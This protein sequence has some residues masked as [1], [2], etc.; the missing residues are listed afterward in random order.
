MKLSIAMMVKNESKYL[1]KCLEA[2]KP[3]MKKV[4]S[5]LIIVDTGS[6]DNTV[7]IAREY[8]D[9]VYFHPW[10]NNFSEMRNITIGYSRG[11]WLFIVDGDEILQEHE[12]LVNFLNGKESNKFNTAVIQIKNITNETNEEEGFSIITAPRLFRNDE[13]FHYEGAVHNQAIYKAPVRKLQALLVHYGYLH[14]DKELMERKFQRTSSI[15]KSELE[16]NPDNVYYLFQLSTTYSMHQEYQTALECILKAVDVV[17]KHNL[18]LKQ[19]YYVFNEC[20]IVYNNLGMYKEAEEACLKCF[21]IKKGHLDVH[22]IAGI[23]QFNL[24]KYSEAIENF[25][26]YLKIIESMHM[27]E[28]EAD[29]TTTLYTVGKVEDAYVL[30]FKLFILVDKLEDALSYAIKITKIDYI[31]NNLENIVKVFVYLARFDE[32][33]K[34]FVDNVENQLPD[35]IPGFYLALENNRK[36]MTPEQFIAFCRAFENTPGNYGL[37]CEAR[38]EYKRDA[39][40]DADIIDRIKCFDFYGQY[41]YYADI[42][43]LWMKNQHP[44][45]K[46]IGILWEQDIDIYFEYLRKH[47]PGLTKIVYRY[48][49]DVPHEATLDDMRIGKIMARYIILI[50]GI[51]EN[52]YIGAFKFYLEIGFKYVRN[53]Y[54]DQVVL[55]EHIFSMKNKEEAFLLFVMKAFEAKE[56]KSRAKYLDKAKKTYND[57]VKP[58]EK[59][60]E[61][62]KNIEFEKQCAELRQ[63]RDYILNSVRKLIQE[64]NFINA[65][66]LLNHYIASLPDDPA[67]VAL[68]SLVYILMDSEKDIEQFLPLKDYEEYK[69]E[70]KKDIKTLINEGSFYKAQKVI[71]KYEHINGDDL[72]IYSMK[73]VI[74]IMNN[75]LH[76]AEEIIRK[77]LLIDKNNYDL[78]FNLAYLYEQK[79]DYT[80]A[81]DIYEKLINNTMKSEDKLEL[82]QIISNIE[83]EQYRNSSIVQVSKSFLCSDNDCYN[84]FALII[85]TYNRP[86]YLS[87]LL[88]YINNQYSRVAPRILVLDSSCQENKIINQKIIDNFQGLDLDCLSFNSDISVFEKIFQ[89]IED[90]DTDYICLCADDDFIKEEGLFRSLIALERDSSLFSVKGRNLFYVKDISNL[91]EYDFFAGLYDSDPIKRLELIN[92]GFFP[93]LFY[94]VFR[95]KELK[96]IYRFLVRNKELLPYNN[97]FQE[98]LFYYMVV[99][100]GK[101]GKIDVDFNIRDK[102]VAREQAFTN[103]PHAVLDKTFNEDYIRFKR[104]FLQYCKIVGV[105]GEKLDKKI[106]TIFSNFLVFFLGIPK[107]YVIQTNSQFD[108]K[109]LEKGMKKSSLWPKS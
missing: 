83:Q 87:R 36:N 77:G 90:I 64:D 74:A 89:G 5:E 66:E 95:T 97:T 105:F 1:K 107:E 13:D 96:E 75:N 11:E 61:K 72:D 18:D 76:E 28:E 93:S 88:Y 80:F 40:A 98:Y 30:L 27:G 8:T 41:D 108:L 103:F 48:L 81:I 16:K 53:V 51:E 39:S 22:Y 2:L 85:P 14:T 69:S 109:E 68:L 59:Y 6:E 55:E 46:L 101:I 70:F 91:K 63:K 73:A 57:M 58:L 33:R 49:I 17:S 45:S 82:I 3:L 50:G 35:S 106:D 62:L 71:N 54:S 20:A 52:E 29:L 19:N 7:E 12:Q 32:L 26:N 78:L 47:Y 10:N 37:L 25:K 104:S 67:A 4:D 38:L 100:T 21:N 92:H 102:G 99:L 79:K 60:I 42:I 31:R 65:E 94:Q 43:L 15:L 9:N 84:N 44:L 86:R 34:Y 23:A 56:V 24:N